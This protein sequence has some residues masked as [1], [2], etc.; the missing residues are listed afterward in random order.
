[1]ARY[2]IFHMIAERNERPRSGRPG[3]EPFY[4]EQGVYTGFHVR[5]ESTVNISR[6]CFYL[7]LKTHFNWLDVVEF[8]H[9]ISHCGNNSESRVYRYRENSDFFMVAKVPG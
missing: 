7:A 9:V 3:S 6:E 4:N 1:M 5:P 8:A 2:T